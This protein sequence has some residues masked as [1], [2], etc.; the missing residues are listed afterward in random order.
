MATV[1]DVTIGGGSGFLAPSSSTE[2]V[3]SMSLPISTPN[4]TRRHTLRHLKHLNIALLGPHLK[5][6]FR[7]SMY[8]SDGDDRFESWNLVSDAQDSCQPTRLKEEE[9]DVG[10]VEAVWFVRR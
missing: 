8:W 10:V 1:S 2:G 7:L 9:R 5:D 3:D 4:K 6:A